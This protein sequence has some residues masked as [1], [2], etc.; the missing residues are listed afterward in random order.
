MNNTPFGVF[1]VDDWVEVGKETLSGVGDAAKDLIEGTV[2]GIKDILTGTQ[3]CLENMG[4]IHGHIAKEAVENE[5]KM[6]KA[7]IKAGIF[8]PS[9]LAQ[10]VQDE[11]GDTLFGDPQYKIFKLKNPYDTVWEGKPI[12]SERIDNVDTYQFPKGRTPY[13]FVHGMGYEPK[14]EAA[15][16]FYQYFEKAAR[17][18]KNNRNPNPH[19]NVDIYIVSYNTD[20]TPKDK[21]KITEVLEKIIVGSVVISPYSPLFASCMWKALE[22]RARKTG[23]YVSK[24]LVNMGKSNVGM[25]RVITHSLG[26][27]TFAN[28]AHIAAQ[29][30]DERFLQSWWCM[31]AAMPFFAFSDDVGEFSLAPLVCRDIDE[32]DLDGT[33]VWY[34]THDA[35]LNT[36]YQF[37]TGIPAMGKVGAIDPE[38]P[39]V[40]L[41][42]TAM[43]GETHEGSRGY[44]DKLGTTIRWALGTE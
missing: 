13:I 26:C 11:L 34:S 8:L 25:G 3:G 4:R 40:N 12:D 10:R 20:I 28:A 7:L 17:M 35:I 6:Q 32:G 37:A 38:F 21:N 9:I 43:V 14:E 1:D 44:F 31:A 2:E 41:D 30:V 15:V 24:F 18:F 33:I 5:I 42:K 36:A 16:E 22:W 19:R 39:V 29:K 23:E 27:F